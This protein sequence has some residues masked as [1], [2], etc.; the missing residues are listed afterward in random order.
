M[1]FYLWQIYSDAYFYNVP[2]SFLNDRISFLL[3]YVLGNQY[4]KKKTTFLL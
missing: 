1:L 4:N 2:I 3:L